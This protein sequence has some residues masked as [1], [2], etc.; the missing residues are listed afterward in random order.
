MIYNPNGNSFKSEDINNDVKM[1]D[2]KDIN[3]EIKER[4]TSLSAESLPKEIPNPFTTDE[5]FYLIID[6]INHIIEEIHNLKSRMNS[7]EL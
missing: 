3:I 7:F 2:K 5:L 6:D 4:K 1:N